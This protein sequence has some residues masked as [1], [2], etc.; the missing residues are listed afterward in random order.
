MEQTS[1]LIL[2]PIGGTF[3]GATSTWYI[4]DYVLTSYHRNN[5]TYYNIDKHF[6]NV[7]GNLYDEYDYFKINLYMVCGNSGT[8]GYQNL[9]DTFFNITMSGLQFVNIFSNNIS[10]P[11]WEMGF[12]QSAPD[13]Q[14]ATLRYYDESNFAIFRKPKSNASINIRYV[15]NDDMVVLTQAYIYQYLNLYFKITPYEFKN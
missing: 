15:P 14:T 8:T 3:Q 1:T 4:Q 7:L 13:N 9:N 5:F 12:Y 6:R 2:S 10:S 11:N